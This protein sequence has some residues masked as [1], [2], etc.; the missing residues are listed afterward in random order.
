MF[1]LRPEDKGKSPTEPDHQRVSFQTF[2]TD[3]A[4]QDAHAAFKNAET[5]LS[6]LD[7]YLNKEL[8]YEFT[9]FS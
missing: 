6:N 7:R 5:V 8:K 1:N 9:T 2:G 3:F 4:F